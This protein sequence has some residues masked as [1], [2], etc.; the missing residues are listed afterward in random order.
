M[1]PNIFIIPNGKVIKVGDRIIDG[2]C[3]RLGEK[4]EP[5][6]VTAI[7]KTQFLGIKAGYQD[8]DKFSKDYYMWQKAPE[9]KYSPLTPFGMTHLLGKEIADKHGNTVWVKFIH[10]DGIQVALDSENVE[11]I[12]YNSDDYFISYEDLMEYTVYGKLLR[13]AHVCK[14]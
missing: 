13:R 9:I 14:D 11:S 7:G 3:E 12:F 4:A 2:D 10:A 6:L 8:E 5:I 1:D